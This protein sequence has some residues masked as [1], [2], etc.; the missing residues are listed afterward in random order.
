MLA[1]RIIEARVFGRPGRVLAVVVPVGLLGW[2]AINALGGWVLV[3]AIAG[4]GL[5]GL[6]KALL[7]RSRILPPR[8]A[9]ACS[10]S[11]LRSA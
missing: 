5:A 10:S 8:A 7:A 1:G 3:I 4:P 6:R 2:I 9:T 11:D